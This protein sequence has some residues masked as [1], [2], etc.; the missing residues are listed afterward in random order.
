MSLLTQKDHGEIAFFKKIKN[1]FF[2]FQ[3]NSR[4]K[5]ITPDWVGQIE[6]FQRLND[7]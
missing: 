5:S 2:G 4:F 7:T 3:K 6:K 1:R